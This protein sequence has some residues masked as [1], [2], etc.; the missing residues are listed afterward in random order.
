MRL[1]HLIHILQHLP[2]VRHG[3]VTVVAAH[4]PHGVGIGSCKENLLIIFQ[5]QDTVVLQENDGLRG[6]IVSR[7]ALLGRIEL[8]L[9]GGV[10]IRIL[11][12][13]TSTVLIPEHV[14]HG[15]FQCLRLHQSFI[16]GLLQIFVVGTMWEIHIAAPIDGSCR[17]LYRAL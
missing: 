3:R 5:R 17:L 14:L 12:E 11:I 7:L 8:N 1:V 6:D 16:N 2:E 9:L 13:Q 15:T 10:Q 4:G